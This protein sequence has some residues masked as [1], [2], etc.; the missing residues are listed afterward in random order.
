MQVTDKLVEHHSLAEHRTHPHTLVRRHA[1]QPGE[2]HVQPADC[3][4]NCEVPR[5]PRQRP[6]ENGVGHVNQRDKRDEHRDDIDRESHPIR[7][8]TA[9]RVDAVGRRAL[10]QLTRF[11]CRGALF[12]FRK[13]QLRNHQRARRAQDGCRQQMPCIDPQR[14]IGGRHA[15]SDRRHSAN[16]QSH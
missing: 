6:A 9:Q 1:H 2:R 4:L 13:H 15:A 16:H 12:R 3:L 11:I 10:G 14:G 7:R 5:R 8:P